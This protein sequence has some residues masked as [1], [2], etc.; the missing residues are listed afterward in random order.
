LSLTEEIGRLEGLL[1]D[2]DLHR[3]ARIAVG[4]LRLVEKRQEEF[5]A[6]AGPD[7]VEAEATRLAAAITRLLSEPGYRPA[8]AAARRFLAFKRDLAQV[9]EISGYRGSGHLREMVMAAGPEPRQ[10]A[11]VVECLRLLMGMTMNSAG[12][13]LLRLIRRLPPEPA[14]LARLGFLSEY[15]VWAP[16][17][18][19]LRTALLQERNFPEQVK[20]D[21]LEW[22]LLATVWMACSY[23]DSAGKH[24]I[25]EQL[26][27]IVRTRLLS[28]GVRD[29][30][31]RP[32]SGRRD[33]RPLVLVVAELYS[34]GH[35]MDRCYR[36]SLRALRRRFRTVL[37][38][39]E[40]AR[41]SV[42]ETLFDEVD[43][44][45]FEAD[46]PQNFLRRAA[47]HGAAIAYFP[48]VGMRFG[49][50]ACAN[51]RLAPIQIA[52]TGH[53]ATTRSACVDY[54]VLSE[55]SMGDPACFSETLLL[56]PP[57]PLYVRMEGVRAVPPAV[58]RKPE[59]VRL[60]VP[61]WIRKVSPRFLDACRTIAAHAQRPVQFR[62]FP[63]LRGVVFQA[64]RRRLEAEL[65]AR[66]YPTL[67]FSQYI[68]ALNDCDVHLSTFPFGSSNGIVDS[69]LQGLPVVTL[70]GAEPHSR[71]DAM[72]VQRVGQPDWL[73]A[74]SVEGYICAVLRLIGDDALRVEISEAILAADPSSR[75]LLDGDAETGDFAE[76]FAAVYRHHESIQASGRKVW[77]LDE[78][79]S[80]GSGE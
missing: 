6:G 63:N 61:A 46:A 5:G 26:N 43:R 17:A 9:F 62:F 77:K 8:P 21:D 25:K 12:E 42:D 31:A 67:P 30:A 19:R 64:A 3:A 7:A 71:I 73:V 28:L 76:I 80:L 16:Q 68:A 69:M 27:G 75:L 51:V 32:V 54:V 10:A 44:T 33:E 22:M 49:S 15:L 56:R 40:D 38:L 1:A 24:D 60:A 14:L 79:R 47:S 48:S 13:G 74:T 65:P 4:I 70:S 50:I 39:A 78:L 36:A 18:E 55:G 66:V 23:A 20:F 34:R 57:G 2:G 52:T 41:G 72:L 45:P 59:I 58:R 53:P 37:M 35:A 29:V 11:T